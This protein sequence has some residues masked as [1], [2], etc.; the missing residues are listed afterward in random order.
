MRYSEQKIAPT[1]LGK[2]ETVVSEVL[3]YGGHTY[4]YYRGYEFSMKAH[5][6]LALL[7]FG[8]IH[9]TKTT[10]TRARKM[11]LGAA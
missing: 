5:W 1:Q 2:H 10:L 3:N 7:L 4:I 6:L 8:V 11:L 9:A